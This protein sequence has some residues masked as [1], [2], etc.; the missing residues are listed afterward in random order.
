M[1]GLG[2]ERVR[3]DVRGLREDHIGL[4]A[5]DDILDRLYRRE[6][7]GDSPRVLL[8]QARLVEV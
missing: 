2:A 4:V 6:A 7:I 1:G 8:R 3:H 5:R